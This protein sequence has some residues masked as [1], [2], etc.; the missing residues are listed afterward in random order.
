MRLSRALD[1]VFTRKLA[2]VSAPAGYGKTTLLTA[3]A[4][5][6][7]HPIA[8]LSLD[9]NDRDSLRLLGGIV[10]AWRMRE[11]EFGEGVLRALSLAQPPP[12]D[13]LVTALVN[14]L[15]VS[16]S[17]GVLILDDY[18][19]AASPGSDALLAQLVDQAPAQIHVVIATR[20]DPGIPLARLRARGQLVELRLADLRLRLD[21]SASVFEHLLGAP[22][23]QVDVAALDARTEGWAAGVQLAAL[24]LKGHGDARTLIHGFS[25]SHRFV[26]DYLA[27]EVLDRLPA[28]VLDFLLRSAL[29]KRLC[30][31]LCDAVLELEAGSG[32]R[33]LAQLE[34]DNLFLIP[35]DDERRWYRYHHLFAELLQQ[36]S[37]QR[38]PSASLQ[39]RAALW[40]E[41]QGLDLEAFDYAVAAE[42]HAAALRLAEGRGMPLHFR[43]GL[44]PVLRWLEN[45]DREVF[46]R[47]PALYV[48]HASALLFAGRL[49]KIPRLVE[50][51]EQVLAPLESDQAARE[52]LGRIAS[53]RATLAVSQHDGPTIETQARRALSYVSPS[54]LPVRSS[55]LW[56]LG[57]A[58][59][60]KG[61][62]ADANASYREALG[63]AEALRH[64]MVVTLCELG[65]SYL[66][67]NDDDHAAASAGYRRVIAL[68]GDPAQPVACQAHLGLARIAFAHAEYSNAMREAQ[69]AEALARQ[70]PM[71]DRAAAAIVWQARIAFAQGDSAGA[72]AAL[73]RADREHA[74]QFA[75]RLPIFAQDYALLLLDLGDAA[76]A[77]R[78]AEEHRLHIVH[79]QAALACGLQAD[80]SD[81]LDAFDRLPRQDM[82][83]AD[84]RRAAEM[85]AALA[86]RASA[87]AMTQTLIEPLSERELQV[88]RLIAEGLSNREIAERLHLALSSVKGHNLRIFAKLNAR[89]RTEAIARARLSG[90]L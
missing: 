66:Q 33:I 60:L 52:L 67:E 77:M 57:Y 40:L 12:L 51:A 5:G 59:Q 54:N 35:L 72:H 20:E 46:E 80:A 45:L 79:A 34:H 56:N 29:L 68:C 87:P 63:M 21:E 49:E 4:S 83:A 30:G 55:L 19:L 89:S 10:C 2:L 84:R 61:A 88:L 90:A 64:S 8:W 74:P 15:A 82:A 32:A 25:G 31:P 47:Y 39:L 18:H 16:A 71:T 44:G 17:A 50:N 65:I 14:A 11:P 26:L 42:S 1:D 53:I 76:A 36:R 13:A 23:P 28:D 78:L 58:Q 37:A 22:L 70:L 69:R 6:L 85:R 38:I 73:A 75:E 86:E 48:M 3:W 24:S 41:A 9:E 62:L 27:S 7:Q 43:G 81:V